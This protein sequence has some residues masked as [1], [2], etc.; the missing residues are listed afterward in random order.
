MRSAPGESICF[1]PGQ[2]QANCTITDV[3]PVMVT[4]GKEGPQRRWTGNVGGGDF[5]RFFDPS[6]NRVPHSTMQTFYRRQGPCL[7]EVS[8]AGKLGP[9]VRHCSTVSL[10][11]TD[12]IV[13]GIYRIRMD[14]NEATD[15]S[16]F[17]I[18]QIGADTYS[19]TREQ[20]MAVGNQSGLI[21]EWHC[22]WGGNAY[23]TE[24]WKAVGRIPWASLH[25]AVRPQG[26]ESY[27]WANRGIVIRRWN[28]RLGGKPASPWLAERGVDRGKNDS[29][30]LDILPPP[31]VARLQ[32]GDFVEATIEHIVMPQYAEDYYGPNEALRDALVHNENTWRMIEREAMGNDR[33]VEMAEGTV[34][35]V[36]PDV[37]VSTVADRA[38][39]TLT[40]GLA[41]VPIT[42]TRLQSS[43]G[44]VLTID[45]QTLDQS[46]HGNDFWQTDYDPVN[47]HW[48]RTYNIPV[49]ADQ[50]HT[51]SLHP[52][53]S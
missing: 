13:R 38:T 11:R 20:K 45:G 24:P 49:V 16:R 25:Q 28:A 51:V 22:Q 50:V 10:A 33:R 43:R 32:R 35:H 52:D 27:A 29:S 5:F 37:R 23:R 18:F 14:V 6:G 47:Q 44:H 15:F 3:R 8:F 21:N 46:I 7:T 4:T 42:F 2:Q 39:F 40:G 36:Y 48:S 17:V 30:T 53:A 41:Y 1:E 34:E 31:G 26:N 9:S 19:F 12:D